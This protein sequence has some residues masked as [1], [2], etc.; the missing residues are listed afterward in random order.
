MKTEA[1]KLLLGVNTFKLSPFDKLY[2]GKLEHNIPTEIFRRK[3]IK[4]LCPCVVK[5][6][7]I[8]ETFVNR[9]DK[10]TVKN[11]KRIERN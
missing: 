8:K 10:K 7:P 6:S 1:E 3:I 5:D 2:N 11:C 9:N 4:I